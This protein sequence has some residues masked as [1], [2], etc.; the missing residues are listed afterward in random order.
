MADQYPLLMRQVNTRYAYDRKQ[1]VDLR[2]DGYQKVDESSTPSSPALDQSTGD[3]RYVA[4]SDLVEFVQD[5]LAGTLQAGSNIIKTYDD[6]AGTLTVTADIPPSFTDPEVVRDVIGAALIPGLGMTIQVNDADNTIKF[7][8]DIPTLLRDQALNTV[9]SNIQVGTGYTLVGADAGLVVEMTSDSA[10]SVTIPANSV[11][12]FPV[13][14]VIEIDQIGLGQTSI[15]AASGVTLRAPSGTKI[16][17]Q[18]AAATLRK[19]DIDEWV[20]SGLVTT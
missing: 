12:A 15:L 6:T 13:G 4:K 3:A 14:T 16:V 1:E 8:I 19:R 10:N 20:L 2:F 5:I 9:N 7:G 18:Y 11:V 17:T